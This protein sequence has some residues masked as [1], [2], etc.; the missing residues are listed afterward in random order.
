MTDRWGETWHRLREWTNG[1][2][3]SERLAAQVLLDDGYRNLDPRHPLGGQD[4]TK[5]ATC[6]RDGK[7]WIMAVYFP[8]GQKGFANIKDKFISDL[9]GVEKHSAIGIA[10]VTNQEL[11]LA[12]RTELIQAASSTAVDLFHLERITSILDQPNMAAVRKQ[13]LSI[14]QSDPRKAGDVNISANLSA[15]SGKHG[16]GGDVRAEGGMGRHGASGGNVNIEPGSYKAGDGGIGK[17]G[18]VIIKGGD[19]E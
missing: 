13:F 19:A 18:D 7:L 10:F 1:Q 6:L 5:D 11:R 2:G 17:G 4:G 15:G 8:R 9:A 14:D 3:P 16:P 12:E